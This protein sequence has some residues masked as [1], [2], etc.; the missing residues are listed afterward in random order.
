MGP[1]FFPS[2]AM[3]L[4]AQLGPMSIKNNPPNWAC[5]MGPIHC[6][7][8]LLSGKIVVG[9]TWCSHPSNRG[10]LRTDNRR[11]NT[12]S[13]RLKLFPYMFVTGTSLFCYQLQL[14]PVLSV[15]SLY[16]FFKDSIGFKVFLS[17]C[18]VNALSAAIVPSS[19]CHATILFFKG[20]NCFI[21]C[22]IRHCSVLGFNSILFCLLRHYTIFPLFHYLFYV[23]ALFSDW[24]VSSSLNP[25]PSISLPPSFSLSLWIFLYPCLSATQTFRPPPHSDGPYQCL[26]FVLSASEMKSCSVNH[27][28]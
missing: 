20:F 1:Q 18:Y 21:I 6:S 8:Y 24:A 16:Y 13:S 12:I 19:A 9:Y 15:T 26:S 4:G 10:W 17:V 27:V 28:L 7:K 11:H 2:R 14:S 3:N 25:T 23:I 22:L 5:Q